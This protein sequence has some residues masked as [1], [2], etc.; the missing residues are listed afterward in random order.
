MADQNGYEARRDRFLDEYSKRN[1]RGALQE[2]LT[3]PNVVDRVQ[4]WPMMEDEGGFLLYVNDGQ[5]YVGDTVVQDR[6]LL[7]Q[8]QGKGLGE[9]LLDSGQ[10]LQRWTPFATQEFDSYMDAF[11]SLH[12]GCID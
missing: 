11:L 1:I 8:Y 2:A 9:P 7:R 4:A 3:D 10:R 5:V 12:S 6:S